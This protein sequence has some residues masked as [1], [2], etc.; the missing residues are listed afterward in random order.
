MIRRL[1]IAAAL[2]LGLLAPAQAQFADQASYAGTGA[3]TANAQTITLNN[4]GAYTQIVGVLVKYVPGATNTGSATINVNSIGGITVKKP[5]PGGFVNLSGGELVTGQTVVVMYD[6]TNFDLLSV[7]STTVGA[8]NL[9][10]SALSSMGLSTNLQIN[11]A[12]GSNQLTVTLCTINSGSNTCNAPT[13]ANPL[14]V[15]FR[16]TTAANGDPV[17]ISQQATLAITALSTSSFGC[18]T[19][20]TCRLW[21]VG[22]NNAGTMALCLF[23]A[24]SGTTIAPIN[25]AANQT[26]ASGTTGGTS[27][28]TYYCSTSAVTSKAIRILGY[29]EA[30]WLSG[31]GWSTTPSLVQIFGPG[32]KKPGDVVQ[33]VRGS[34]ITA[35]T[36]IQETQTQTAITASITPT[37]AANPVNV[38]CDCEVTTGPAGSGILQLSRGTTP[39]LFGNVAFYGQ[40]GSGNTA[41]SATISGLDKPNTTSS[42]SYYVFGECA[43]NNNCVTND[44]GGSFQPSSQLILQE[45]MGSLEPANDNLPLRM[46]G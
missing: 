14:L 17:I 43:T 12:V 7:V 22:I 41:W 24:L 34:L 30:T 11:A 23:N 45:I 18:V 5:S 16:D 38:R 6:G 28:Q 27:A 46:V 36:N 8:S 40:A 26:S 21:V 1:L 9:A 33:I 42:Q 31:T 3:G 25:E 32:I 2:F 19:A 10:N 35:T 20:T 39:T 44:S 37:S 13:A 15:A 29:V 4:V